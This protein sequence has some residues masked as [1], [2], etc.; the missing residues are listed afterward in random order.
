MLVDCP[1]CGAP[2]SA[3][4]ARFH[5]FLA[6]EFTDPDF[7]AVHHLTVAAYML[8]HSGHLSREGW[9]GMRQLLRE[10]LI[11]NTSPTYIRQH[12]KDKVASGAR[13]YKIK[14]AT[15]QPVSHKVAWQ[16]TICDVRSENAETYR[17]D[18][19]V[20]AKAVLD[21]SRDGIESAGNSEI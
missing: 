2:G 6:M 8:Q 15:G 1:E 18:I 9:L 7:G 10:F 12:N 20:W 16:K 13:S 21:E 3:C 11:D 5:E 4:E 17:A 14:S 19:A